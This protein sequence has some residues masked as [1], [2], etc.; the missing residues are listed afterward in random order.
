MQLFLLRDRWK[1]RLIKHLPIFYQMGKGWRGGGG[2]FFTIT[3]LDFPCSPFPPPPPP[4]LANQAS[5]L[6]LCLS[7]QFLEFKGWVQGVI[8]VLVQISV[9]P[10]PPTNLNLLS[11]PAIILQG[12]RMSCPSS[13]IHLQIN[14]ILEK[15]KIKYL[16]EIWNL[17]FDFI[18][19]RFSNLLEIICHIVF[20]ISYFIKSVSAPF[21]QLISSVLSEPSSCKDLD[22]AA[23]QP[24]ILLQTALDLM[25][26][27]LKK[28]CKN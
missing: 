27:F 17:K 1:L 13:Q 4:Q 10:F 3:N 12:S 18:L 24:N 20:L 23:P 8:P 2:N 5:L 16:V 11:H 7:V 19:G 26:I 9:C 22:S 14:F 21:P 25:E 6:P 28:F 15:I